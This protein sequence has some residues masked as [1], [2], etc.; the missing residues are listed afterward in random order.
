MTLEVL[1][2]MGLG[3]RTRRL[4]PQLHDAG[5][6]IEQHLRRREQ[7]IRAERFAEDDGAAESTRQSVSPIARDERKRTIFL[8][9][10]G[11]KFVDGLALE[12]DVDEGC[13]VVRGLD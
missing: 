13:V 3:R 11:C 9:Q 7:L 5:R 6:L 4:V 12:I 10:Q 8:C 1:S 2:T